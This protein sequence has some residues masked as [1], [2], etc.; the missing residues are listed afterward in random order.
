VAYSEFK[1]RVALVTGAG[2]GIGGS[3][4]RAFAAEGCRVV[5]TDIAVEAGEATVRQIEAA[6]GEARFIRADLCSA[7]DIEALVAGCVRTF[8]GL[9]YACNAAGADIE[10][11]CLADCDEEIFDKS[12]AINLKG[13]FLCLKQEIRQM[14]AQGRGAIVNISSVAAFRTGTDR[15]PAYSAAK[16]GV[17]ALGRN[18]AMRYGRDGVRINTICPGAIETP[19]LVSALKGMNINIDQFGAT[20]GG[21]RR[22]GQPM[23]VADVVMWLCSDHSSFVV[24]HTLPVDGGYLVR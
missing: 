8:G 6:A 22:L 15:S 23:E 2:G 16:A 9:D 5:V 17:I 21:L 20:Y 14:V 1:D 10:S 12:I 18:A 7:T 19:M 3:V 24:G 13:P 11:T 4:A